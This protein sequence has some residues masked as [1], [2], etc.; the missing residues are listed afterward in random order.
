MN[1]HAY[2]A[3]GCSLVANSPKPPKVTT[4]QMIVTTETVSRMPKRAIA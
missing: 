3:H 4:H 1:S 2:P